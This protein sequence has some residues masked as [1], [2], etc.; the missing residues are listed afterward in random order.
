ME[1]K[2][3]I[4][5]LPYAAGALQP[6]PVAGGMNSIMDETSLMVNS[7]KSPLTSHFGVLSYGGRGL[8]IK[9][10]LQQKIQRNSNG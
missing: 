8:E 7:I 9:L 5:M 1:R 2:Y 3:L 4:I 10:M 6:A